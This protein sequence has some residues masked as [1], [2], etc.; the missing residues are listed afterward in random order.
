M[1]V[2]MERDHD[3]YENVLVAYKVVWDCLK[4]ILKETEWMQRVLLSDNRRK[5]TVFIDAGARCLMK[6]MGYIRRCRLDL[7]DVAAVIFDLA[8]SLELRQDDTD[9]KSMVC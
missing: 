4:A 2:R 5:A 9:R 8:F 7:P 1:Q 6:T 3:R